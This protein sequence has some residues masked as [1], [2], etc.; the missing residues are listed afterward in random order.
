MLGDF[1]VAD[2]HGLRFPDSARAHLEY[3]FRLGRRGN[4]D[5]SVRTWRRA[6][7]LARAYESGTFFYAELMVKQGKHADAVEPLRHRNPHPARLYSHPSAA[8][9]GPDESR[10][11]R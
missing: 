2:K 3:G 1:G 4:V 8:G 11:V 10:T 5:A 9:P 7:K 6:M